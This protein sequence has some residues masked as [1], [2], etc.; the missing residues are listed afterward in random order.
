MLTKKESQALNIRNLRNKLNG[1]NNDIEQM[2]MSIHNIASSLK[3]VIEKPNDGELME[4]IIENLDSVSKDM[5]AILFKN[6][7]KWLW[8]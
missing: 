5:H 4:C 2:A 7:V 1:S 3:L 8:K 6:K